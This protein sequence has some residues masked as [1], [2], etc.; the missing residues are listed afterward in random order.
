MVVYCFSLFYERV[1][2]SVSLLWHCHLR[3]TTWLPLVLLFTRKRNVL[4]SFSFFLLHVVNFTLFPIFGFKNLII[5]LFFLVSKVK[6]QLC[7]N[8]CCVI[9]KLKYLRKKTTCSKLLLVEA[10]N[11]N[12]QMHLN[13]LSVL[14]IHRYVEKSMYLKKMCS[15]GS[16]VN[17]SAPDGRR[18]NGGCRSA[19][20]PAV[21]RLPSQHVTCH[22]W[23]SFQPNLPRTK[24]GLLYCSKVH[25]YV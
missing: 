5:V 24:Q 12:F 2:S 25:S 8:N 10:T 15:S 13:T 19:I 3:T 6:H 21:H 1:H 20:C 17:T 18:V 11:Q 7:V 14:V 4:F 16:S 23:M 9:F 22:L